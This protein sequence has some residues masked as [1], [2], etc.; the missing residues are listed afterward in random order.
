MKGEIV[1]TSYRTWRVSSS[2]DPTKSRRVWRDSQ[3]GW[4]CSC[5]GAFTHPR[6]SC[7]HIRKVKAW[8]RRKFQ[9]RKGGVGNEGV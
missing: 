9:P 1:Q 7:S 3:G 8:L 5:L 6:T 2:S 4:H